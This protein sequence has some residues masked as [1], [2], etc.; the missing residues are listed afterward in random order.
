MEVQENKIKVYLAGG[1]FDE[2]QNK[3]LTYLED[4]LINV[5]NDKFEVFAPRKNIIVKEDDNINIQDYVFSENCKHIDDCDLVIASTV[6]KD[7]GTIWETGYA[8]ARNKKIIYTLFD[9]RFE[10][11]TFNLMLAASGIAAF[12]SKEDFEKFIIELN[13]EN[14]L[15]IKQRYEGLVE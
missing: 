9:N 1:W 10:N 6:S 11:V 15:D 2:Y 14:Y 12:T 4:L 5:Y 8:Y 13:K 3:A 7:M